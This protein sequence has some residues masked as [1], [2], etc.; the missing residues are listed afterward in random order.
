MSE[1]EQRM[2]DRVTRIS[3]K[4]DSFI[5]YLDHREKHIDTPRF[6]R[7]DAMLRDM[8]YETKRVKWWIVGTAIVGAIVQVVAIAYTNEYLLNYYLGK[9]AS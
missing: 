5:A 4:I 2:D 9:Y 7:I 6:D 1:T 3:N 8:K